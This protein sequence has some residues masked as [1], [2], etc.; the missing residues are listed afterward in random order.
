MQFSGNN[1]GGNEGAGK[2]CRLVKAEQ[3]FSADPGSIRAARQFVRETLGDLPE[4]FVDDVLLLVSE[5]ATNSV[6]HAHSGFD[7]TIE[8]DPRSLRI[9]IT[10]EGGDLPRKRSPLMDEPYGR[11]LHIVDSLAESWGVGLAADG[12]KTIWVVVP[13]PFA[14]AVEVALGPQATGLQRPQFD[15]LV[16]RWLF[17]VPPGWL[18]VAAG[19]LVPVLVL[20]ALQAMDDPTRVRPSA[21]LAI[22]LVA[23]TCTAG[24]LAVAITGL[25]VVAEFWYFGLTPSRTWHLTERGV[26]SI[27]GMS[28]LVV[29]LAAL[30]Y[31]LE[32][33]V[34]EVRSLDVEL[35]EDAEAQAES[36]RRAERIA[37][38]AEAVLS[39]SSVLARARS[40]RAVAE[41]AL[42]EINIPSAPIFGSVAIVE[43]NRLQV[44]ASR[45]A[46]P[47][48]I[49]E[50]EHIDVERSTW[51]RAVLNG[52]AAYV[53]DR[54]EFAARYP[55]ALSLQMFD[56]GS[57]L[58]SP[59]RADETLGLLSLHFDDPQ[60]LKEYRLYFALVSELIGRWLERARWAESQRR[61]HAQLEQAFA[62]RDRI[63][64]TLSTSLLPPVLP[65]LPGF[66]AAAWLVPAS[67]DEV[68][69]DFYDLFAVED[70]WVAVLGDV[71]GKGAEAA[72]VTSLARYASRASALENPDTAHIARVAN[73]ALVAEPSDLFCT[74][75]IVRYTRQTGTV[76]VTLA[77]H[78]QAR[79]VC[80]G[81]VQRLGRFGAALGLG[82]DS[83][84]VER[85]RMPPGAMVVLFS[86]GIV[87]RD[88]A[89][90]ERELDA[91]LAETKGYDAARL[92]VELRALVDRLTPKH[93]DDVAV[94]VLERTH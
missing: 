36:R 70:G 12:G 77:G 37:S 15:D 44:I 9:E 17:G 35:R 82:D 90:G 57:W 41:A 58:V 3:G 18:R 63:A 86:D 10:D 2:S 39:M 81:E 78:L 29:A 23:V 68:A 94:M 24:A 43:H 40:V 21:F 76:A 91:F 66:A 72:A 6:R 54:A 11:G 75:A 31:R 85:Y 73:Q 20:P 71:C 33:S 8:L 26:T 14:E 52:E 46:S 55:A 53:E 7:L 47:E 67:P 59:F 56:S 27:V 62:E 69:G 60:P 92:S 89:F 83:P 87:E 19:L 5:L 45:G 88:P 51:L 49:D 64:R 1:S 61:S 93:P 38:Q 16:P 80:D 65:R 84:R 32:R 50:L 34:D 74:A 42:H 22:L 79:M 25:G 30:A 48:L 13:V 4:D 28:L